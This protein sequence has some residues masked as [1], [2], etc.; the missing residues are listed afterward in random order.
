MKLTNYIRQEI[1][2]G[3]GWHRLVNLLVKIGTFD[4]AEEIYQMLLKQT[5]LRDNETLAFLFNQLG[6]IHHHKGNFKEALEFYMQR[7]NIEENNSFTNPVDLAV[8]YNN[9][10]S[11]HLHMEK[12]NQALEFYYKTLNIERSYLSADSQQLATTYS[13]I[14]MVH[15]S[16]GRYRAA[17][18]MYRK[19]LEIGLK[20]LLP[21]HP[22]RASE[23]QQKTLQIEER[24]LLLN[25]LHLAMTYCSIGLL[26]KKNG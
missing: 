7:L 4:K 10:A 25:D 23:F 20:S 24:T 19:A 13:N 22:D 26:Y 14:G 21:I 18:E 17:I 6:F 8:T 2:G 9:I 3:T 1:K 15:K 11:I 5:F 16:N 12:Y